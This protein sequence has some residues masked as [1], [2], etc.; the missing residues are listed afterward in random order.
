MT[1]KLRPQRITA[2]FSEA[3]F[4]EIDGISMEMIMFKRNFV[5]NFGTLEVKNSWSFTPDEKKLGAWFAEYYYPILPTK[6]KYPKIPF[7]ETFICVK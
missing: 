1:T 3:D 4:I 2:D 5:G 6:L 7:V